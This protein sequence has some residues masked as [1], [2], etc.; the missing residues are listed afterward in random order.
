MSKS[1]II[2]EFAV[3]HNIPFID[4]KLSKEDDLFSLINFYPVIKSK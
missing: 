3:K 2:K 4:I 1:Q